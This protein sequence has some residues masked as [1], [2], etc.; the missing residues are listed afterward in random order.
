LTKT[1]SHSLELHND[2]SELK[3]M[4]EWIRRTGKLMELPQAL[5]FELDLC[6][7][8]AV[9]NIITYAYEGSASHC[10]R[11]RLMQARSRVDIEIE[12]D[13]KPFNPLEFPPAPPLSSLEHA[14]LGG[15]GIHLIR[16]LM[17]ECK[18]HRRD[19]KNILT[20]VTRLPAPVG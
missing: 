8:E 17:T 4:S 19:G 3:R 15:R 18:Y 16:S 11:L 12:D 14:P 20:M 10:I 7:T 5:A 13:G 9:T 2:L 6:A 1:A